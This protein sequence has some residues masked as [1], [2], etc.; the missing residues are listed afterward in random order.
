ME[1]FFEGSA[2]KKPPIYIDLSEVRRY[3]PEPSESTSIFKKAKSEFYKTTLN[4][5]Q[6]ALSEIKNLD[7]SIYIAPLEQTDENCV[8]LVVT[9][10]LKVKLDGFVV[11]LRDA[12]SYIDANLDKLDAIIISSDDY[13]AYSDED[14]RFVQTLLELHNTMEKVINSTLT[15]DGETISR[16]MQRAFG[17]IQSMV[18]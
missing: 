3:T 16:E 2:A 5:L 13:T 10:A 17:K 7:N 1:N 4:E 9:D 11:I 6:T 8:F 18:S 12:K 15:H 14:K